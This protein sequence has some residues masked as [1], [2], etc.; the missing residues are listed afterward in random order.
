MS[1]KI[2]PFFIQIEQEHEAF[3]KDFLRY[4]ILFYD[5]LGF[6]FRGVQ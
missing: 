6:G 2:L 5:I 1:F 4:L 3:P